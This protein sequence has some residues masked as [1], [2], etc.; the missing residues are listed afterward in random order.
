MRCVV[1]LLRMD[2]G[3]TR[4]DVRRAVLAVTITSFSIAALMGIAALLGAGDFGETEARILGTTVLVGCGSV[5][6]LACLVPFETRWR[7][8]SIGGFVVT[9]GTVALAL[10]MIWDG[11][12][13]ETD[14]A[15]KALGVG[16]TLALTL[17]QLCLLLGVSVR[18]PSVS[19]LV[20]IT[21]ALAMLLAGLVISLI[22]GESEPS[23]GVW[24]LLGVM[25]ILD[26]LG[27]LVAIAIG[28]FGRDERVLSVTLSP[29]VAE[30][31]QAE[32]R[33]SGRSV[34]DLVDE[35]LD[36]YLVAS[37]E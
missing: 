4:T 22:V 19:P 9:L 17:A 33:A 28:V 30:R 18:R 25:A 13:S 5:L 29:A 23:D 15:E 35:A 6:T 3:E 7:V 36:R 32:S 21:I 16:V 2:T 8:V 12:V 11:S 10:A 20:W 24:R 37:G 31:V 26:V 34:T 1:T 27:T 14:T